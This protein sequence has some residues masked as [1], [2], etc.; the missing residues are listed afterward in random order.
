M[1]GD[2][3]VVLDGNNRRFSGE[4]GSVVVQEI[5]WK[6]KMREIVDLSRTRKWIG[7]SK[8]KVRKPSCPSSLIISITQIVRAKSVNRNRELVSDIR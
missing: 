5:Q 8:N 3:V 1:N 4:V 7:V 6:S 2:V